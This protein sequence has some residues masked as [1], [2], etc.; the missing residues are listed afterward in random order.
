VKLV[1]RCLQRAPQPWAPTLYMLITLKQALPET[2]MTETFRASGLELKSMLPAY[3][4][5]DEGLLAQLEPHGLADL[6]PFLLL[7]RD[8]TMRL[9][10]VVEAALPLVLEGAPANTSDIKAVYE[11]LQ[12]LPESLRKDA[13]MITT[14]AASLLDTMTRVTTLRQ[15]PPPDDKAP[16]TERE[17]FKR[18]APLLRIFTNDKLSAQVAVLYALQVFCFQ[19]QH[20]KGLMLR[21]AMNL[22]D[23]DVVDDEGFVRWREEIN[24]TVP[25]KVG[26]ILGQL[27]C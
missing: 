21:M 17:L 10:K 24:E 9:S 23:F 8:M 19:R 1:A 7:Q 16:K 13:Q 6:L 3:Q 14:L 26:S 27:W 25:G 20:P 15:D 2:A 11:W 18:L 4:R 12:G 22:Y 5:T